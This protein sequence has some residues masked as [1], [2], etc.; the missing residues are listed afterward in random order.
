MNFQEITPA[1]LAT[2]MKMH[3]VLQGQ[4]PQLPNDHNQTYIVAHAWNL[5]DVVIQRKSLQWKLR[6]RRNAIH[7]AK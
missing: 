3:F 7:F 5:Q 1:E 4:Y 2:N 6:Y